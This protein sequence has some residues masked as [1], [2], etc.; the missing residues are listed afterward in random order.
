MRRQLLAPP[1]GLMKTN[2]IGFNFIIAASGDSLTF[3][4][5]STILNELINE[6]ITCF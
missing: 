3:S 2:V 1:P 6:L 4:T 5:G